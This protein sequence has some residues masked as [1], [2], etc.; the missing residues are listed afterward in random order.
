LDTIPK[1]LFK[2]ADV[3]RIKVWGSSAYYNLVQRMMDYMQDGS[4]ERPTWDDYLTGWK[5]FGE[6]VKIIQPSHCF[7][8]GVTAANSFNH[9]I[10]NQN[11]FTGNVILTEKIG[12]TW[13]RSG[14]LETAGTSTELIFVKHLGLPFSWI[15]WHDYLQNQHPVFMSWLE[16]EAYAINRIVPTL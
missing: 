7:C 3:D 6:V 1:V 14:R 10:A 13:A 11:V 15:Q 16:A 2:T 9:W 12:G 5:V 4:P 8:I